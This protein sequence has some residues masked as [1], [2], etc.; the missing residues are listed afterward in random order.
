LPPAKT[1]LSQAITNVRFSENGA[2]N[3]AHR[4]NDGQQNFKPSLRRR[5]IYI[6]VQIMEQGDGPRHL[7][8]QED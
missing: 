8:E 6:A 4:A 1:G 7:A 3:T 2:V 5:S